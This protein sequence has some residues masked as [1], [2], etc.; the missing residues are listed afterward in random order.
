M[1]FKAFTIIEFES[2]CIKNARTK[3]K[4]IVSEIYEGVPYVKNINIDEKRNHDSIF[5]NEDIK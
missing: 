2:D 5:T 1:I 3:L 4:E